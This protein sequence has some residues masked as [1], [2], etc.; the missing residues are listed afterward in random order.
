MPEAKKNVGKKATSKPPCASSWYHA[1]SQRLGESKIQNLKSKIS[2]H[3]PKLGQHFLHDQRYRNRI[4]EELDLTPNDVVIEIGPGRGAMTGLLA[5][6]ARKVIAVEVDRALAQRLEEDF[7]DQPGVQIV[8]ADILR[9]DLAALCHQEGITQAFVFG[10]LPYYITS[11]ILHRLFAQ[12]DSIR[13]MGLL[14]Q[15]EVGERL[16]AEPGT[17]DYG[18]LSIATQIFSQPRIA[19]AVP[20]GA[21]SPAPKVQSSLITF[22]M[23]A[24]FEQW[25]R[26]KGDEFLEF[27]KHCFAQKRKN[28]LNNL[29]GMYLRTRLVQ[30]LEAAGKP[31]NLR[32]E[33][34]SLDDFATVFDSLTR[35]G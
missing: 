7:R 31:V 18:Y 14:M 25:P 30:A 2:R 9:V 22:R 5:G 12:R 27:V 11:P 3:R 26:E 32:A 35:A 1:T 21:F 33:E 28:L 15:R 20:P 16:T 24:K 29:G 10:N 23:K 19:V 8:L 4:L 6:R 17:R 34:L 13:S